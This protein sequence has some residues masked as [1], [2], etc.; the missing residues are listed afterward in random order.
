M[1]TGV[2]PIIPGWGDDP[3]GPAPEEGV[4]IWDVSD[5]TDP[6][7]LGHWRTGASGT[8]RN[9][10]GGGR[11]VHASISHPGFVGEIYGVLDIDDPTDP[12]LVGRWWWP[13][14]HAGEGEVFS[15]RDAAKR[16]SGRPSIGA[17][18]QV[19]NAIW[20]HGPPY[21]EGNRVYC[22]YARAGMPILDIT[23]PAAPRMVGVFDVYPPLGSSIALHTAVPVP[24]RGMVIVNSEAL[25]E[26]CDEPP[27]FAAIVDVSDEH[28]PTLVSLFPVPQP[29]DQYGYTSFCQKG[30]RFGPHNQ[31]HPQGH[32]SLQP[33][34]DYVYLTY[35]NAG[36][37]IFDIR[38]AYNPRIAGFFIPADPQT[39]YGPLPLDLVVQVEDVLVD[40]RGYIYITEKNSGLR[41]LRFTPS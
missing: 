29:P 1:V 6:K 32:P 33:S 26:R 14:Q 22:S 35:F 11:Y 20:L 5:P 16:L 13:G 28:D 34:G 36:L 8:H 15:S 38:D 40:R 41:I 10:Y 39:R 2:G 24:E 21:V 7:R 12:R 17:D 23:D 19:M 4:L 9:F 25:R 18:G 37:Q 3:N 30:G 27:A 31:H